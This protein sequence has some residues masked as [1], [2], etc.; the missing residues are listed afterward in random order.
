[1]DN[2]SLDSPSSIHYDDLMFGLVVM[3]IMSKIRATDLN[4]QV[5][6]Q[7]IA[8]VAA[9]LS[10]SVADETYGAFRD[11]PVKSTQP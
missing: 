1:M 9:L 11:P 8:V 4:E 3:I 5:G 7:V 10:S 6:T 2:P